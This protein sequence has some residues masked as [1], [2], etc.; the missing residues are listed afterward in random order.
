MD[1]SEYAKIKISDILSEFIE[2]YNLHTV[3]NNGWVY[4][5]IVG[6]VL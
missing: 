3:A 4:F 2:E 6:G 5:E 1:R